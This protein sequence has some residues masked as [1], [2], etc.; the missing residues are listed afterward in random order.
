MASCLVL[1]MRE[2][3]TVQDFRGLVNFCK[4]T[5]QV[6]QSDSSE[7]IF[8]SEGIFCPCSWGSCLAYSVT[9][10]RLLNARV[11]LVLDPLDIQLAVEGEEAG[12]Q[13]AQK[14]ELVEKLLCSWGMCNPTQRGFDWSYQVRL[15]RR[16]RSWRHQWGLQT[17]SWPER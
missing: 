12:H 4:Q 11:V 13:H 2:K 17:R 14:Q 10:Q 5:F 16:T 3:T 6:P 15:C 1:V 8:N 7:A 9:F